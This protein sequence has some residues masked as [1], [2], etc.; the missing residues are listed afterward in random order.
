MREHLLYIGGDWRAGEGGGADATSPA[1]GQVFARTAVGGPADVDAAVAAAAA[2][3]P[4]W[5]A[6]SPFERAEA[7]ALVATAVAA[8]RDELADVLTR[9][10]G[11]PLAESLDEV[12]EL[13]VYFRMAGEDAKRLAGELPP[14]TSA[15][16]RILSTR[17]P[18]GVVGVVSPWNWPYTMGAEILAPAM[19]AGNTVVWVPAPTTTACCAVLAEL[20]AGTGLDAGVFNFVPGPGPVVGDALAGH[21]GIAGVGFVGSVATGASIA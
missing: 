9:D 18:L 20:I 15:D 3:W 17:V 21:P 8:H 5:A 2:A 4:D 19:A 12:D 1:T 7:C 6:A 16:R 11:K 13:A 14:S 10:Q